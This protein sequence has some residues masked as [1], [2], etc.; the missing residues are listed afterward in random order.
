MVSPAPTGR[1]LHHTPEPLLRL[2][3]FWGGLLLFLREIL[4]SSMG[5]GP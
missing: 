4:Q 3:F 1:R 5:G 2:R